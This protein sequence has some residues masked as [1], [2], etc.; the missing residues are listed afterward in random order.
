ME[1]LQPLRI[2]SEGQTPAMQRPEILAPA[3]CLQRLKT[4]IAFGADAVYVGGT[5]F[6]LRKN[7]DNFNA[8]DLRAGVAHAH[9]YGAKVYVACNIMPLQRDWAE[10]VPYVTMLNEIGPDSVIVSDPGLA[11]FFM[12]ETDIKVHVSTQASV[13]NKATAERWRDRGVKRIVLAREVALEQAAAIQ[14]DIG[15]EVETFVHGAMC[16]S[17]SG[18]CVISNYTAG[19]DAN[20]GGCVQTCRHHFSVHPDGHTESP[21]AYT[22]KVMNARDLMALDL[23]PRFRELG[24]HA[25]KIEGRMKSALY[26]AASSIAY[27]QA[28][29]GRL[30]ADIPAA[31][32]INRLSNRGFGSGGLEERPYAKSINATI[33]GFAGGLTSAGQAMLWDDERGV[34]LQT[35]SDLKLGQDISWLTPVGDVITIP[36]KD[37]RDVS[38]RPIDRIP[39]NRSVWIV[40]DQQI[41]AL[42]VSWL[43]QGAAVQ[44]SSGATV[45]A[46]CS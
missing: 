31:Q 36:I 15:V 37:L 32:I 40:S 44:Q 30:S 8:A 23:M 46:A 5:Q 12:R 29:E 26:V 7:A 11:A 19:R 10:I 38:G 21:A 39:A 22:A 41:P 24:I 43:K 45:E 28:A 34:L 4:A 35:R 1:H 13:M 2:F 3:G 42:S 25:C 14:N 16:A 9:A 20:R 6:S 27:R 17:F 33:E 18:K